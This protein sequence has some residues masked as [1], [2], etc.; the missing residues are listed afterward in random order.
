MV[1]LAPAPYSAFAVS[2]PIPVFDPVTITVFPDRSGILF[3]VHI[4]LCFYSPT[5]FVE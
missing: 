2:N 3:I 1:T 5:K 4:T